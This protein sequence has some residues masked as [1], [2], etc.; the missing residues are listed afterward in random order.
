LFLY[1]LILILW[2]Q[3]CPGRSLAEA[4]VWLTVALVL[5]TCD[6]GKGVDENG[7]EVDP[8]VSFISGTIWSVFAFFI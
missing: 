1:Q 4:G 2:S 8:V 7:N 3:I 5:A 6:I